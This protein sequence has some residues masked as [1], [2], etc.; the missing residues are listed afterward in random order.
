[1][2]HQG[3]RQRQ[4]RGDP[5]YRRAGAHEVRLL[6]HRE[7]VHHLPPEACGAPR[8]AEAPDGIVPRYLLRGLSRLGS[9]ARQ[10]EHQYGCLDGHH[11][12]ARRGGREAFRRQL[13]ARRG[14]R[15]GRPRELHPHPR[16]GLLADHVQLL[17]DRSPEA[18]PRRLLDGPRL[19]ARAEFHSRL[20]IARLYRHPVEPERH[21]RR[22]EHQCL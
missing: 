3:P 18:L 12:Q 15:R 8:S 9:Q 7:E 22:P 11:A 19:P 6:R 13:R 10:R 16:Q 4:R 14:V 17:P 5:G 20:R 21:V 2:G 1:M